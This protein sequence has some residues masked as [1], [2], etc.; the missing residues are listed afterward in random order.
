MN[1]IG[2][3]MISI[4]DDDESVRMGTKALLRSAGFHAESFSS[5]EEFLNSEAI[6]DSGCLILDIQMPG[7]SGLELQ[8]RLKTA[9]CAVPIIFITAHDG[10]ENRRTLMAGGALNVFGKPFDGDTLVAAIQSAMEGHG[11]RE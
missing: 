6:S 8:H 9:K 5:A 1:A 4:V 10:D 2:L 3:S 11:N 7:I